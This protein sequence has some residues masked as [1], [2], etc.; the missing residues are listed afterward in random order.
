MAV[1][2]PADRR[3]FSKQSPAWKFSLGCRHPARSMAGHKLSNYIRAC[4]QNTECGRPR[5]QPCPPTTNYPQFR[6]LLTDGSCCAR[7]RA[8]SDRI[9]SA[10]PPPATSVFGSKP[11]YFKFAGFSGFKSFGTNSPFFRINSP[12]NHTSPPPHSGRWISTMSQCTAEWLPL[13]H[14]S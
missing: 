5:P 6:E 7:S 8:H 12:S 3:F 11:G 4:S 13:S 2:R 1:C 10:L 14:S 9:S